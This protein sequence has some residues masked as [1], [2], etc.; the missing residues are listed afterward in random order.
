MESGLGVDLS[1]RYQIG[2]DPHDLDESIAIARRRVAAEIAASWA[3]DRVNLAARLLRAYDDCDDAA[4]LDEVVA[5]LEPAV[6]VAGVGRTPARCWRSTSP[7][8]TA[9][10]TTARRTWPTCA[11]PSRC[12]TWSRRTRTRR[13]WPAAARCW[14]CSC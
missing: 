6:M 13:R 8:P 4:L 2:G 12:T 5:L 7:P 1:E 14:P 10:A 9:T 11:G 3:T